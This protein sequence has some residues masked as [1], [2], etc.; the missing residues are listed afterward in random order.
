MARFPDGKRFAFSVFD[1]T[2]RGTVANL[3]PVYDLLAGLGFRTTKSVWPL[4]SV[5]AGKIGGDSLADAD[6]LE[7]VHGLQ[8]RGFEV[9]LHGVR[10]HDA[11][12]E[13]VREG[14][15]RFEELLGHPPRVHCN[16]STNRDNIYWGNARLSHPLVKFAYTVPGRLQRRGHFQGHLQGSPY[17]W[18]DLCRER[19]TYVRNL[20]FNAINLDRINPTM[21][22]RDPR[23][24]WVNWWFSSGDGAD[25]AK[26]CELLSEVNQDRL[27]GE[28]GVCIVYTHFASGFVDEAGVLNPRFAALMERLAE[29]GGWYVPVSQLLDQLRE[30]NG[31]RAIPTGE[32]MAMEWRWLKEKLRR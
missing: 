11:P 4:A 9:A 27:A 29:L 8:A 25:C 16:H 18:G 30:A 23:R 26:F 22:Y 1:D 2:D 20:T 12:R 13:L 24:P 7:F 10:N 3:T 28:G 17:F 31:G 5:P 15:D 6:Y 21:P 32:L 19:I 14:L